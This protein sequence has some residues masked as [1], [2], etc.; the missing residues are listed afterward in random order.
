MIYRLKDI[1][2]EVIMH[3]RDRFGK[4][5]DIGQPWNFSDVFSPLPSAILRKA[6]LKNETL[7][8]VSCELGGYAIVHRLVEVQQT[9]S[10]WHKTKSEESP[11][12]FEL[13]CD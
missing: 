12:D 13:E 11:Y 7:W 5:A 2:E 4:I 6:C 9:N 8:I 3:C 10:K 1:P